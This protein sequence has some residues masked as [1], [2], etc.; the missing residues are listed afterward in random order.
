[1]ESVSRKSEWVKLF[2]NVV[3]RGLGGD[4]GSGGSGQEGG[5]GSLLLALELGKTIVVGVLLGLGGLASLGGL[6]VVKVGDRGGVDGRVDE[7]GLDGTSASSSGDL[8]LS[9]LEVLGLFG[10]R[11][12]SLGSRRRASLWVD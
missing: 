1:M 6:L 11:R 4:S 8:S 12:V 10:E 2:L 5:D 3:T 9:E 7:D